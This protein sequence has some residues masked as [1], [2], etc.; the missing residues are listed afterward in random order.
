MKYSNRVFFIVLVISLVFVAFRFVSI[1]D[2]IPNAFDPSLNY[3]IQ[4]GQNETGANNLLTAIYLNYRFFD[5]LFEATILFVVTAGI[6]Y[7][8]KKDENVR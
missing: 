8:G 2:T 4:N 7:M 5:S 6:F 3:Y 1:I